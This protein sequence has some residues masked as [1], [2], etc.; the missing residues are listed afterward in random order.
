[1]SK[2]R[3]ISWMTLVGIVVVT[4]TVAVTVIFFTMKKEQAKLC[5]KL[6]RATAQI[7]LLEKEIVELETSYSELE[8][9][10][11][12][13]EQTKA[14]EKNAPVVY[15]TFDDGPSS[16]TEK[17]LDILN[18]YNV[19]ATFF[20]I[21]DESGYAAKIYRRLISEGHSVGNHTYSHE[22]HDIYS[23]CKEFWEEFDKNDALFFEKTGYHLEIMR[24]PGGSNN[25]VSERYCKGIMK[26]LTKEAKERGL[27]YFDWNVSSLDAERE[28]QKKEIIISS[29]LKGCEGQKSSIVLMHDNKTKT[30][31]VEA[32]PTIIKTLKERGYIFKTLTA[33][34]ES[35]QFLK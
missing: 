8:D 5:D 32:L 33:D 18:K 9:R 26:E 7:T 16:N 3:Y 12:E 29:V 24:F 28:V 10:Y 6:A 20:V 25:T 11:L 23:S 30:T 15:L 21:G 35:I 4:I 1:M 2:N 22:Y 14:K 34:T 13:L 17:I 31:T 19:K 27:V